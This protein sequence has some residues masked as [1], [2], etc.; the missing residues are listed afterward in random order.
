MSKR[1]FRHG[2]LP[3]VLLALVAD[4]PMHSYEVMAELGRRFGPAYRPSPGSIYP[5][6]EA[7]EHEKLLAGADRAGKTTYTLTTDGAAALEERGDMLAELELRTGVHVRDDASVDPILERFKARVTRLS[8]QV[9]P[10]AVEAVLD[11]AAT[12]IERLNGAKTRGAK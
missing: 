10:D 11:R 6:I 4:R 5:A 7:L 3:L 8:G 2:E 12:E 9:D 1:F